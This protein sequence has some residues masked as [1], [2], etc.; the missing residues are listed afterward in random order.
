MSPQ[1]VCF[2][3]TNTFLSHH[4]TQLT[5]II[6]IIIINPL[7]PPS[8]EAAPEAIHSKASGAVELPTINRRQGVI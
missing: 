3:V 1:M 5:K 7:T 6:I 8:D 2:V 4:F